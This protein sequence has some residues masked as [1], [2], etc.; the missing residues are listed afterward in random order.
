MT[1]T[2]ADNVHAGAELLRAACHDAYD[3]QTIPDIYRAIGDLADAVIY[4]QQLA[5]HLRDQLNRL[6]ADGRLAVNR[7]E[8]GEPI[9]ECLEHLVD[10]VDA[11]FLRI[12]LRQAH[13]SASHLYTPEE[14]TP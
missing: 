11:R 9:S 14:A 4:V 5:G 6:H 7:V 3:P 13:E 8:Y 10:V 1:I 12:A 2:L